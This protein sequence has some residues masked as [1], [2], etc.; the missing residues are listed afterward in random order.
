MPYAVTA[1]LEMAAGGP[2]R[3]IQLADWNEDGTADTDVIDSAIA[4]ADSFI[5]S[6]GSVVGQTPLDTTTAP[7]IKSM[8]ANEAIYQIRERR[9]LISDR[10]IEARKERVEYLTLW[11]KGTVRP[12]GSEPMEKATPN[13]SVYTANV[14]DNSRD[15][16]KG[17]W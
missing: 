6:F 7:I 16:S 8:A 1:D 2:D 4:A 5:D 10:D 12:Q 3:L 13:K 9:G 14:S 11:R 17:F 15:G